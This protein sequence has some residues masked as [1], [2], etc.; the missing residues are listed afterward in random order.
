MWGDDN[1]LLSARPMSAL[2][3]EPTYALQQTMSALP[4]IATAKADCRKSSCPL[5]P[6]KRSCAAQQPMSALGQK[7]TRPIMPSHRHTTEY[8]YFAS[9][10]V[11]FALVL[12]DQLSL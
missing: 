1:R 12:A 10:L 4:L 7:R 8:L 9:I 5:Y 11:V 6:Q 2:G 3:Q